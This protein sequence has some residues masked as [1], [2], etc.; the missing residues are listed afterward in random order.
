MQIAERPHETVA[1]PLGRRKVDKNSTNILPMP[2]EQVEPGLI[3]FRDKNA[4]S[5][6]FDR[7]PE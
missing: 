1:G 2:A 4:V 7:C 5:Q 6:S 3:A